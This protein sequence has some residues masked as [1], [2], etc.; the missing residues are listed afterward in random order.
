MAFDKLAYNRNTRAFRR[1]TE[2]KFVERERESR[3]RWKINHAIRAK[4][5]HMFCLR[6]AKEFLAFRDEIIAG[7]ETVFVPTPNKRAPV[8][9]TGRLAVLDEFGQTMTAVP[10]APVT[11]VPAASETATEA[12]VDGV[13]FLRMIGFPEDRPRRLI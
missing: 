5:E 12:P 11:S 1:V 6:F 2:P 7:K 10:V 3:K 9:L 8:A 13:E 4:T